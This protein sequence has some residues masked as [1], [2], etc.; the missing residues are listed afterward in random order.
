MAHSNKA[1]G[2]HGEVTVPASPDQCRRA[3]IT[4]Q[5]RPTAARNSRSG[6]MS[7]EACEGHVRANHRSD[8]DSD[9][10]SS[11]PQS[12][13]L[14]PTTPPQHQIDQDIKM[15]LLRDSGGGSEIY[16]AFQKASVQPPI[17]PESLAELDM[18]RIINNPK[19][20]HDVNFDREL[21]F[22][23]NLDGVRGKQKMKSADEYWK[24]LE[25]ELFMLDL[26]QRRRL[27]AETS[28]EQEYWQVLMKAS[29]KRL[30]R[31]FEVVRDILKTLVP[32]VD[33]PKILER[34]DV[35]LLIQQIDNGVCDLVDLANWLARVLKNH[36]APM[37]D[38]LVDK[39]QKGITRGALEGSQAMMVGGLR[40][41][42]NILEAM[43]L[44]VANHQ[45]RHMRPLL[46]GDTINFQQRYNA[47][48]ISLGKLNA[49]SSR[50]WLEQEMQYAMTTSEAIPDYL[51]TLSSALLRDLLF[52]S[53]TTC[54]TSTFYLDIDRLRAIRLD[55]H[56][57]I[58]HRIC[59]DILVEMIAPDSTR[60][61]LPDALSALHVALSAIVGPQSRWLEHIENI[62][63]E[64]VR[65]VLTLEGRVPPL[66]SDLISL[67]ERKLQTDLAP[68]SAAFCVHAQD[69]L[70][71]LMPK[72][73][74]SVTSHQRLP[75][76]ELQEALVPPLPTASTH[77]LGFGAVCEP[78]SAPRSTDP[79]ADLIRR[80]THVVVLHWQVWADLVYLAPPEPGLDIDLTD[81]L[82]RSPPP[83][84]SPEPRACAELDPG[85]KFL[86]K[87][88]TT[89]VE[90]DVQ[91]Q[92]AHAFPT[93][94]ASPDA[95]AEPELT[96]TDQNDPSGAASLPS[97]QGL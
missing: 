9:S 38:V 31:V 74:D 63:V 2:E 7:T 90:E 3:S 54:L 80:F 84:A 85:R 43:K 29:R 60:A 13:T 37:R 69:M 22:R 62:A 35:D 64:I 26:V 27:N 46:I 73:K 79:D 68:V 10:D 50:S 25:G 28:E 71:R 67:T 89:V 93:P 12:P 65:I 11:D 92:N 1:M 51:E 5:P 86:P 87:A 39:M 75:A 77:T 30:P 15:Y 4:H 94:A 32:D 20:R 81:V 41:L 61:G 56:N 97:D 14:P 55:M 8:F 45:I 95:S 17:N 21:H 72:I 44:D 70:D 76:L 53:S 16:D 96:D 48:R 36:C 57:I 23:P 6:S 66:D 52:A 47:H 33:Q 24:A 83:S 82:P 59:S 78:A 58:C 42:L 91:M 19:L 18:P 34:L 88:V 40:Q 49:E